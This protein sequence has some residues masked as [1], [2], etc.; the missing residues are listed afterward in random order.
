[1]DV[2]QVL[3]SDLERNVTAYRWHQFAAGALFWLPTIMLFFVDE[4]GLAR[5]LQLQAV[6]YLTVVALEVPSGRASDRLGRVAT[7][8]VAAAAWLAAQLTLLTAT[9]SDVGGVGLLVAAQVLLA[10]GYAALSGTDSTFHFDTIEALGH[11]DDYERLEAAAR[12]RNLV[13]T[14][15]AAV[16]GGLLA[17]IGFAWVFGAGAVAAACQL[18]VTLRLVEPPTVMTT[19]TP[20]SPGRF[21]GLRAVARSLRVPIVA[22]LAIAVVVQVVVVHLAADLTPP[23]LASLVDGGLDDPVRGAFAAGVVGALV[24]LTGAWF[25]GEVPRLVRRLGVPATVIATGLAP[26]IVLGAMSWTVA[27]WVTPFLVFRGVQG[28]TISV[29]APRVVGAHV[30]ARHRATLLS[31]MSL[32]GRLAY[33]VT[34][35]MIAGLASSLEGSLRLAAAIALIGWTIVAVAHRGIPRGQRS[36]DHGHGHHHPETVHVHFHRHDDGHHGGHSHDEEVPAGTFHAHEHHHDE[37]HHEHAH[38]SDVHHQHE[39]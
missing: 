29:I 38:T 17:T 19:S 5:A 30:A 34:A 25:V 7:M 2:E 13:A 11:V 27:W 39:H 35:L 33:G 9:L 21:E 24:A 14:A 32:A 23:Y 10:A 12:R 37:V 22:W 26:V 18:G 36:I 3:V 4:V 16:A 31:T 20:A 8:R 6:Y 1:M 15:L 28:A